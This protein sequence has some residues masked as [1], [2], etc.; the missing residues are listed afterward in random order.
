MD[1]KDP[2]YQKRDAAQRAADR[3]ARAAR[4]VQPLA[5]DAPATS[6]KAAAPVVDEPPAPEW[7]VPVASPRL[8]K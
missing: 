1:T 6:A 5:K 2:Q 7:A 8:K 4:R 3:A